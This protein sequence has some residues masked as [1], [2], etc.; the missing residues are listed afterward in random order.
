MRPVKDLWMCSTPATSP[1]LQGDARTYW[2]SSWQ[3][4]IILK[5]HHWFPFRWLHSSQYPAGHLRRFDCSFTVFPECKVVWHH[6]SEMHDASLLRYDESCFR[7]RIPYRTIFSF[8][9]NRGKCIIYPA[10]HRVI[11]GD[12]H[13]ITAHRHNTAPAQEP[14]PIFTH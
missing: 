4:T 7:L 13:H 11:L 9:T 12:A 3:R 6:H 8:L 2:Y 1:A 14:W 5:C 10:D